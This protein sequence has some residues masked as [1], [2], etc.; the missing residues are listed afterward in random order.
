LKSLEL[1]ATVITED[2]TPLPNS[3]IYKNTKSNT[4]TNNC[5]DQQIGD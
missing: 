3:S 4:L 2:S 1:K 5:E